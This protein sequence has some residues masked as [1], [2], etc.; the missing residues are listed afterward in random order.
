MA[1]YI[2]EKDVYMRDLRKYKR[3]LMKGGAEE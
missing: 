3:D 1:R 2:D